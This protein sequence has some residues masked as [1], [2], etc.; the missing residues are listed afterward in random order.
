MISLDVGRVGD[1]Q[2]GG[3]R[4][5]G[6]QRR[7][8]HVDAGVGG[9]G[10]QDRGRQQLERVAV[11]ELADGVGVRLGEAAGDLAGPALRRARAD[12]A[13]RGGSGTRIGH[14]GRAYGRS[15][16]PRLSSM[17]MHHGVATVTA[18]D[19]IGDAAELHRLLDAAAAADGRY[20]LCDHLRLELA[21]GG[22]PGFAAVTVREGDH[23]AGY[24]QL[25]PINGD[26]QHRA[27]RRARRPRRRHDRP[28]AAGRGGRR[29]GRRR[30]RA[31]AVVGVR[32][33]RRPTTTLAAS[34]GLTPTRALLQ[35]RRPLPTG[36]PST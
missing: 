16:R 25:A 5:A 14:A 21:H 2:V 18:V 10:G 26:P 4:V 9:L 31:G 17:S 24:A 36:R 23:L 12:R 11:V 28:P 6:E 20:P 19:A 7:R 13:A 15:A 29:R 27:R 1:R 34:A 3:R 8:H 35:M 33:H 32:R 30:R 22:G